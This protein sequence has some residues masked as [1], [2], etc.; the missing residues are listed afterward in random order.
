MDFPLRIGMRSQMSGDV[1]DNIQL[2]HSN[3]YRPMNTDR[4]GVAGA[5]N[6]IG[7]TNGSEYRNQSDAS[8]DKMDWIGSPIASRFQRFVS[9][10]LFSPF[11]IGTYQ[12]ILCSVVALQL[13][14]PQPVHQDE[15][16]GKT[17]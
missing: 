4:F 16:V 12:L 1:S 17:R 3:V 2:N 14:K 11:D 7:T 5:I 6:I 15:R 13:T 9:S 8:L 10:R